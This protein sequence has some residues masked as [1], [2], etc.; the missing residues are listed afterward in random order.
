MSIKL[1]KSEIFSYVGDVIPLKLIGEDDLRYKDIKWSTTGGVCHFREFSGAARG[2]FNDGIL[3]TLD[4]VGVGYVT[5]EYD[6]VSYT[7]SVSVREM[8][9]YSGGELRYYLGDMHDHMS[10]DHNQIGRAHV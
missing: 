3:V 5:A 2:A 6:G 8:K 7:A 1:S 10:M 4:K 9:R